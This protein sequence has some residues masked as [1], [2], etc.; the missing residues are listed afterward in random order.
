MATEELTQI[1]RCDH[2]MIRWLCNVKTEQ[3]N[4]TED[5]R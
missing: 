4:S 1:K 2:A 5:L 3:K